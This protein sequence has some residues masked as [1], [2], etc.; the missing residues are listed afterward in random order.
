MFKSVLNNVCN[1][2]FSIIENGE[3]N[4]KSYIEA[5]KQCMR[6]MGFNIWDDFST[7][8]LQLEDLLL[9]SYST[10]KSIPAAAGERRVKIETEAES[11]VSHRVK[12]V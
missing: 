7:Y 5:H 6:K 3:E 4:C 8:A 11:L 9:F 1:F 10:C 2:V 12:A